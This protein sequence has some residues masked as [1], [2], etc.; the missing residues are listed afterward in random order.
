MDQAQ[1]LLCSFLTMDQAQVLLCSFLTMDQAQVS[2]CWMSVWL[3]Y[4]CRGRDH[5]LTH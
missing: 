4:G 3:R 2:L 5:G 1:V